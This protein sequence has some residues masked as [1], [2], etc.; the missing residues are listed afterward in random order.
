MHITMADDR[1]SVPPCCCPLHR[2]FH[3]SL[4]RHIGLRFSSC[5]AAL[6]ASYDNNQ[7]QNVNTLKTH[8]H[9]DHPEDHWLRFLLF[10]KGITPKIVRHTHSTDAANRVEVPNGTAVINRTTVSNGITVSNGTLK[11]S[12]AALSTGSATPNRIVVSSRSAADKVANGKVS[13]KV[14]SCSTLRKLDTSKV[15]IASTTRKGGGD[16]RS[17]KVRGELSELEKN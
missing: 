16:S 1:S 9:R 4:W 2:Y 15:K 5:H 7:E 6:E 13:T 10:R 11:S 12:G 8:C 3:C 17:R 14:S